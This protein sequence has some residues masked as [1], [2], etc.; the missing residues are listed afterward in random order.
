MDFK[1]YIFSDNVL[2]GLT[3]FDLAKLNLVFARSLCN[4]CHFEILP[5]EKQ[6]D[7]QT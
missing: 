2:S 3:K 4:I 1:V 7:L 6:K 5:L